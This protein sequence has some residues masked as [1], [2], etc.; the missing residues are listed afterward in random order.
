MVEMLVAIAVIGVIASVAVPQLLVAYERT[1]QRKTMGDMREISMAL[2]TYR[3]DNLVYPAAIAD[4]Q[5]TYMDPPPPLDGWGTA[6]AYATNGND[7]TMSSLGLDGAPGPA[8]PAN[9][10]DEPFESDLVVVN[11]QFT[12]FPRPR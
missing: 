3:V 12:Q 10:I 8:P 4:L 2:G 5:P 9:W 6:W 11:G 7:Y 1:R